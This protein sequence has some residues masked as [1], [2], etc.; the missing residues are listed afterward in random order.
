MTWDP[1]YSLG[2]PPPPHPGF[3]S[4]TSGGDWHAGWGVVPNYGFFP[5]FETVFSRISTLVI[6]TTSA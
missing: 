3:Q 1:D 2:L 6:E 4:Q 5:V